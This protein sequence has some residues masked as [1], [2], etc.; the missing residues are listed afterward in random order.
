MIYSPGSGGLTDDNFIAAM[1]YAELGFLVI[2]PNHL[3]DG[4]RCKGISEKYWV[5][6]EDWCVAHHVTSG[7]TEGPYN[8]GT[9]VGRYTRYP[10]AFR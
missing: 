8:F 10:N 5:A 7:P 1:M 3:A 2:V 4:S 9:D 6:N